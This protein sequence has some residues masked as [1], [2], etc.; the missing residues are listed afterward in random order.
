VLSRLEKWGTPPVPLLTG[1][2]SL[3]DGE[4]SGDLRGKALVWSLVPPR[5]QLFVKVEAR[6]PVL[7]GSSRR[8]SQ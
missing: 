3:G 6:A 4:E 7:C 5:S 1:A 2:R 8:H